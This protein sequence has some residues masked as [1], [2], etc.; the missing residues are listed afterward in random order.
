MHDTELM[1]Q[2]VELRAQGQSIPKISAKL[3]V[4]IP[5]LYH[6]N[7]RNRSRIHRLRLLAI[8]QAEEQVL[9][10]QQ[11]QCAALARHL[12]TIDDQLAAEIGDSVEQFT[13]PQLISMSASLRRQLYH[14]KLHVGR[15]LSEH[16]PASSGNQPAVTTSPDPDSK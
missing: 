5:T 7:D 6:W 4:P 1:D 11:A 12:K 14:L 10:T 13:L 16:E 8:E 2:F 9:G 3:G 15:S